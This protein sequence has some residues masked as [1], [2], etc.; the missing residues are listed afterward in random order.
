MSAGASEAAIKA[1]VAAMMTAWDARDLDGYMGCFTDDV[2]FTNVFGVRMDRAEATRTH[3][4]IFK[5]MFASSVTAVTD[6]HLRMLRPDLAA[7]DIR[8]EMT[9]S[10]DAAG[11][12]WPTR[13]GLMNTIAVE[14]PKG[15]RF[16]VFHNQDLPPPE[17]VAEFKQM[18]ARESA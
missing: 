13:Q 11:N 3:A 12:D 5:K 14:T 2:D 16:A 10:R 17:R 4:V 6:T 18:M 1:L 8:W 15:W 7:V 9:G